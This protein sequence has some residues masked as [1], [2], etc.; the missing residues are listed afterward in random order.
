ME[1]LDQLQAA[2]YNRIVILG[3]ININM[4][5][6][7]LARPDTLLT[8]YCNDILESYG[9]SQH[10]LQPTRLK[11]SETLIDHILSTANLLPY[12]ITVEHSVEQTDHEVISCTLPISAKATD[13]L[14]TTRN[15]KTIDH[16]LL[17][18]DFYNM[19]N[20]QNYFRT[21]DIDEKSTLLTDNI[22][23]V[24]DKHAPTFTR[25]IR[26][27]NYEPWSTKALKDLRKS[28]NQALNILRH[29]TAK[30]Y[31]HDRHFVIY[32]DLKRRAYLLARELQDA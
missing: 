15:Y 5:P 4:M 27:T 24:F 14:I 9:L 28:R 20:W 25:R 17:F 26:D 21:N 30:G 23:A 29:L 3:D 16:D 10:V 7:N 8:E 19:D 13:K 1:A 6:N 22:L 11:H 2:G 31:R 32:Q 12:D 18:D